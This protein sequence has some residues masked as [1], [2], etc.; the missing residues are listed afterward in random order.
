MQLLLLSKNARMS[1]FSI[2]FSSNEKLSTFCRNEK[3]YDVFQKNYKN[4]LSCAFEEIVKEMKLAR[5]FS[6]PMSDKSEG[7]RFF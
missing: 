3:N 4:N 7:I 1:L 5:I 6:L 2:S